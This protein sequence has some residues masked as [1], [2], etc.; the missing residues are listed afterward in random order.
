MS[1]SATTKERSQ[2]GSKI[3][4]VLAASGS[5]IGLGNIVFFGANAYKYGGGAF[6][7]PYFVALLCVG[8]P[9]M[10]VEFGIGKHY[11]A[12]YPMAMA[13]VAGKKGEF[14][15]WWALINAIFIAMYYIVVL[16]WVA[17]MLLSSM[18]TLPS[19]VDAPTEL[20]PLFGEGHASAGAVFD[21]TTKEW[22]AAIFAL[23]IWAL[24]VLFLMRGTKTIERVVK[25]FVPLMWVFMLLLVV[26]GVTLDGG[27]DGLMYLFTPDWDG[28]AQPEVWK[29]AFSQMFFSLSLGLG[30]MT[31]YASY[32]DS[33]SDVVANGGMVSFLNC[34]FEY[35]AGVAIFAI[36]FTYSLVPSSS[37]LGMSF[38]VIPT[39]IQSLP[40]GDLFVQIV[41]GLFFFL[42][43]IAGLTSSI[44]IVEGPVAALCDKFGW[45]RKKPLLFVAV[46]GMVGSLVFALPS[47][48]H[49]DGEPASPMGLGFLDLVDHWA[50][51]YSLL[52]V[53]FGEA[54]FV[55]WIYGAKRLRREVNE[56]ARYR[57]G[58]WF[59]V[60]LKWVIPTLLG[61]AII[62]NVLGEIGVTIE[63]LGVDGEK[64]LYGSTWEFDE[65]DSLGV[66]V[67]L[68]WLCATV[69]AAFVLT[70]SKGVG[71]SD[72]S[73]EVRQ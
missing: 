16:G 63:A 7:I 70:R 64:G 21:Q 59:D 49:K 72:S 43:L 28:I 65:T 57:L 31:A 10:I 41:G 54:V 60:L 36:L 18:G 55:G 35:I 2:W 9:M 4:F 67:F 3:G 42:L 68:F 58:A 19:T 51:G 15:G 47:M 71:D 6:Y 17:T 25:I 46:F 27:G 69:G 8:I 73:P 32:L 37:T 33:K 40:G 30:T 23:V 26:R 53:G 66:G 1:D 12:A 20:G 52:V 13:K 56:H 62:F 24:N 44:S 14:L 29:G 50:F 61:A 48:F 5:A 38:V 34:G 11:R 45:E 22:W 39:G